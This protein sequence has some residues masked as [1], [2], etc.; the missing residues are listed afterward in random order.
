MTDGEMGDGII[1]VRKISVTCQERQGG[2]MFKTKDRMCADERRERYKGMRGG[3][4][5]TLKC[6]EG[7]GVRIKVV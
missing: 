3:K 4:L 1:L 7:Y 2:K 6:F 5:H